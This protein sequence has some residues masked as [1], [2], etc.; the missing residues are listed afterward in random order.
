MDIA[1]FGK[2]K[3]ERERERE[4][5]GPG[6]FSLAPSLPMKPLNPELPMCNVED[7][8]IFQIPSSSHI[9]GF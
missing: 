5:G 6:C 8:T 1:S 3:R 9:L 7:G 4:V 2:K